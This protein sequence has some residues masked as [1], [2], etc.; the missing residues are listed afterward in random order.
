MPT[1]TYASYE[2]ARGH[3]LG[4][5][6]W[7][8]IDQG[9]ID[10]FAACTDDRQWIHVDHER[11]AAGPFGTTIAHGY[12][13][14]SLLVPMLTAL[15]AFPD[16]GTTVINYGL[17]KLRFIRPVRSGSRVRLHARIADVQPKGEG[18]LL[19]SFDCR[20]EI[21]GEDGPALAARVLHMLVAPS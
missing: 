4:R 7:V 3:D 2:T 21:E 8:T 12:L 13:T 19:A 18:R 9:R 20:V 15:G 17:D 6:P 14:L 1:L 11:A 10:A 5:S 16:D